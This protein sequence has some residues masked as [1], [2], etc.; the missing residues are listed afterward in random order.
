MREQAL[1]VCS[2]SP[3][4]IQEVVLLSKRKRNMASS[5]LTHRGGIS[6]KVFPGLRNTITAR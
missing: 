5:M 2:R 1:S 4:P 3:F 6:R